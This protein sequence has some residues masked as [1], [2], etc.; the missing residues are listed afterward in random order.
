MSCATAANYANAALRRFIP[1]HL[2]EMTFGRSG[3]GLLYR[4]HRPFCSSTVARGQNAT[5]KKIAEVII[6]LRNGPARMLVAP[7]LAQRYRFEMPH[8]R[9]AHIFIAACVA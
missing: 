6:F 8:M 4:A 5:A 7:H 2:H 3:S 9:L 1:C